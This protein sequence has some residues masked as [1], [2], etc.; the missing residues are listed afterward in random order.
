MFGSIFPFLVQVM[1]TA[2]SNWI[3]Y[4][5]NRHILWGSLRLGSTSTNTF[6]LRIN[7]VRDSWIEAISANRFLCTPQAARNLVSRPHEVVEPRLNAAPETIFVMQL[8]EQ[9]QRHHQ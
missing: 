7:R 4:F 9:R 2:L 3:C 1:H 5:F 6:T 8:G